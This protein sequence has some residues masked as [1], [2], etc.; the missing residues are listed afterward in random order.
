MFV[1]YT[2][3]IGMSTSDERL[4]GVKEYMKWKSTSNERVHGVK[5]YMKWKSTSNE[6]VHEMKE[7]MK[8]KSTWNERVHETIIMYVTLWTYIHLVSRVAAVV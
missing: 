7:Y 4:H 6:R 1:W 5:E 3:H 8:W 2:Q